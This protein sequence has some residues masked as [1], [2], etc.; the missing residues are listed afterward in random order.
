MALYAIGD[1]QGCLEA[2]EDLLDTIAFDPARD[3]L[4][5]AGD[6]VARGP[7]SLGVL[8]L[9]RNLGNAAE[10]VL[11]NHDLHL[12]AARYGG[13]TP[14]KK[15]K[16]QSILDAP[17]GAELLDWLQQRPLLLESP[18]HDCVLTHAGIPPDWSLED[19]RGVCARSRDG[20]A[21]RWHSGVHCRYVRQ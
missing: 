7:D 2:L 16:T 18:E 19:A 1:V 9:I 5:F 21:Q 8:R 4:W 6:L 12:I 15:D 20:P 3:H 11:G 14:K 10:S 17:D 13:P